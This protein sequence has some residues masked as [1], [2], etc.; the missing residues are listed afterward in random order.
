M[1]R[2]GGFFRFSEK[3]IFVNKKIKSRSNPF[4]HLSFKNPNGK[5]YLFGIIRKILF[6]PLTVKRL[7]AEE[8]K[9]EHETK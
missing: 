2:K 8:V 5:R 7:V 6:R 4:I 1:F 3:E 9:F